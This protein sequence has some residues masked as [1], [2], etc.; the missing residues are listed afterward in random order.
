MPAPRPRHLRPEPAGVPL[1]WVAGAD[2]PDRAA[3]RGMAGV[4]QR[5]AEAAPGASAAGLRGMLAVQ[6]GE[7][8]QA[9]C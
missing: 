8:S 5:R 9:R 7:R 1:R 4:G 3:G 6:V 2:R